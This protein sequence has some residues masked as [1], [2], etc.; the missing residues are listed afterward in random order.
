V[1]KLMDLSDVTKNLV[2]VT[3]TEFFVGKTQS[4]HPDGLFS[5]RIFGPVDS[6]DRKKTYSFIELNTKVLHPALF[7][8][9]RRLEQKLLVAMSGEK[10]YTINDEG[11]L[12]PDDNGKIYGMSAVVENFD[13]IKF[14]GGTTK[15]D[16]LIHL[17]EGYKKKGLVFVDKSLVIP[18]VYR[19][20]TIHDS[21][22]IT[23]Q[24]MNDYYLNIIRLSLQ[25]RS[26]SG[27][28]VYDLLS[29]RMFNLVKD[30]YDYIISKMA[31]KTG[32]LRGHML[33]KRVDFS[34]RAVIV[35]AAAEL[36]P[37]ELGVPFKLL[38]KLY[39]P[40][41][42]HDLLNS[43]IAPRDEMSAELEKFNG[44][45]LSALSLKKLFIGIYKHDEIP[46]RL[47]QILRDSVERAIKDK[48]VIAKRD[49]A[50]H[51]ESVQAFYPKLVEGNT[52]KVCPVKCPAFNADFDG[53]QMAL[54][55]PI[56]KQAI[57]EAKD[58]LMIS[59]SKDGEGKV[60]DGFEKD[61]AIGIYVLTQDPPKPSRSIKQIKSPDDAFNLNIYDK[62][63][64]GGMTT[65]AGRV[66][67]NQVLPPQMKFINNPIDKKMLGKLATIIHNKYGQKEYVE[68][69]SR[70][71]KIAFKYGT[72]ASPSF[73]IQD[74]DIP[75]DVKRIKNKI[76]GQSPEKV[77]DLL[78]HAE[79][80]LEED[81]TERGT[82]L[83]VIGE[84]GGLKGWGQTRQIL[85]SKG[86]I[87][88]NEGN[89]LPAVPESYTEGFNSK[90]FFQTGAGTRKGISDRV[91]NT[92]D[93]GY[94]SRQLV[95]ALQRVEADPSRY[96]CGT[97]KFFKLK[98]TKDIAPRLKGRYLLLQ[99]KPTEITDPDKLIGKVIPLKSP[100][101]CKNPKLCKTCYGKLLDRNR[102]LFVGVLAAQ[103]IGERGTQMIMKCSSGIV[104][105]KN[106]LW[107]FE[108]L[109]NEIDEEVKIVDGKET[110]YLTD[111][112]VD[113][114]DAA[115]PALKIQKHNPT[116]DLLFISTK[117]GH[118]IIVQANHPLWI[119]KNSI[120]SKY[121][122]GKCRLIGNNEYKEYA[123]SRNIFDDI[124]DELIE[125]QAKD[126]S[127]HDAIWIDSTI[128]YNNEKSI[129][130]SKSGYIC[131]AYCGDGF[132]FGKDRNI[133]GNAIS[134][135]KECDVRSKI[136]L[137]AKTQYE[138]VSECRD[139]IS[140]YDNDQEISN[141]VLGN[142]AWEK[143]LSHNFIDYD[144]KWLKEF[145]SGLIDT[146]GTVFTKSST[147][148]RISTTSHYLVQQ[149][150]AICIKLNYKCNTNVSKLER[151]GKKSI[152]G[153]RP[154]FSIDISF[155]EDPKLNSVKL[156]SIE[157][158][159]Y[160]R[161]RKEMAIRG[162]DIVS[163]IK[164]LDKWEYP[165]YDIQTSTSEFMMNMMQ[166]HN[167][168][169]TGGAVSVNKI[170]VAKVLSDTYS[171]S[172][173]S[174]YNKL[175]KQVENDIIASV[176]GT[177]VINKLEY[178]DQKKD[179]KI[180][181]GVVDLAYGYFTIDATHGNFPITIDAKTIVNYSD[182]N[183]EITDKTIVIKFNANSK[184]FSVPPVTDSFSDKM[185]QVA[186]LLSGKKPWRSGD[187]FCMKVYDQYAKDTKNAD[188]VHFEV[189]SS[190]LL[191][192]ADNPSYP[193][194]LNNNYK[195]IIVNIK[196]IPAL[197][198]WLS[199]L[200]FENPNESITMGLT[201]DRDNTESIL[202]RI[203][204]GNL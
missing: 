123:G 86:L 191:R 145:I 166:N 167:T 96:D 185:K 23:V 108:D 151:P 66:I 161:Y 143:R 153:K 202:E 58:K 88:D 109:W 179:I 31:K 196:Q 186:H 154:A 1:L 90:E 175:F 138:R 194:R 97:K 181:K 80:R 51:A 133:K 132:K 127:K 168:F 44:S 122:N 42:L 40:F 184:I 92:A 63:R 144:K 8:V 171:D 79:K 76:V 140:M 74:F 117:E 197:E 182:N 121:P 180:G 54:Y 68:Y 25:L 78:N 155:I 104:H 160:V 22:E 193:A 116:D 148:C 178:L 7:P 163:S 59:M 170:D 98:V 141:I 60:A 114:K 36:K 195:A 112:Y 77:T 156:N 10:K 21:G 18:P 27:G 115:V 13:K 55:V 47:E 30:L 189:L 61:I 49:P 113:G 35:G 105:Y 129:I 50:L 28:T 139:Y 15:R 26:I 192:D 82:N 201:Y 204:N 17:V 177:I 174:K 110:K 33:G 164:K 159:K 147:V 69:T 101:Y 6:P 70:L 73:S 190:N 95:Y 48:V 119:K 52:I 103:I 107:A 120:H 71:L 19:D 158:I 45:K 150:K 3:S 173:M 12:E 131:G 135:T 134:Q 24:P 2:P 111:V 188:M 93:T 20:I 94:L 99:G 83:G 187:H 87:Q 89:V 65:T 157:E 149:L 53:D 198:S 46:E 203:V 162:F 136:I 165:V 200:S 34:A 16:D 169:H 118:N 4:F 56:T 62:V 125:V 106:Q 199:A 183:I 102:T 57:E 85:V 91:L 64:F 11:I 172:E 126:L 137:E 100:L 75:A 128:A 37:N 14:R 43:G 41:V 84:A 29:Y 5:E 39:E 146:D 9:I 124:D 67:F 72:L 81:F 32:L 152:E 176:N 130:P 38:V 142:Y